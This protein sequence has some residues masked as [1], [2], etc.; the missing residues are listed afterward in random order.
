MQ[1]NIESKH[2]TIKVLG[3]RQITNMKVHMTDYS[4]GFKPLP[5]CAL[6][7][8]KQPFDINWISRH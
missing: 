4:T 8:A 6:R 1:C 3:N 7:D 2:I 5:F